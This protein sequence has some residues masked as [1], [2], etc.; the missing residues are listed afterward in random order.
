MCAVRVC[1]VCVVRGR[2]TCGGV[3]VFLLVFPSPERA[4]ERVHSCELVYEAFVSF[5]E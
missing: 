4:D 2:T 5:V 3:R 1:E